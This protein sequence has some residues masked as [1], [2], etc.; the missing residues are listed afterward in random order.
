MLSSMRES[1]METRNRDDSAALVKPAGYS[2]PP[3]RHQPDNGWL[4]AWN[5]RSFLELGAYERA[6]GC[7]RGH[8][9]NLLA[10]WDLAQ[11]SE[12]AQLIISELITNSVISVRARRWLALPPVRVWI[13]GDASRVNLL[14]WDALPGAPQPRAAGP[15]EE[16]GRGL[17]LVQELSAAWG[18]Y[19]PPEDYHPACAGGKVTWA[20]IG[21]GPTR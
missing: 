16:N 12:L 6:P 21:D 14:V 11:H 10:E 9:R 19:L 17:F 15:D 4:L 3:N 1:M 2:V 20:V 8:L 18:S 13:L 5:R 7:A